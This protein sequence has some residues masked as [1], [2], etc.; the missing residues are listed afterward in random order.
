MEDKDYVSDPFISAEWREFHLYLEYAYLLTVFGYSAPS[1]D[2]AAREAMLEVWK[3]NPSRGLAEIEIIDVRD[4]QE[5]EA[6]WESFFVRSHYRISPRFS[7][8]QAFMFPRRSCHAF[9]AASLMLEP[10]H[11]QPPGDHGSH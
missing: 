1:E 8:T 10:W 4:R 9:A 3:S 7:H 11:G 6:A 5:L 2:A